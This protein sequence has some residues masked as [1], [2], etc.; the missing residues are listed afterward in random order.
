MVPSMA[1]PAT[2]ATP[3]SPI[4]VSHSAL[5]SKL[6]SRLV[7]ASGCIIY[8]YLS[9]WSYPAS[10]L[11][12]YL[13]EARPHRTADTAPGGRGIGPACNIARPRIIPEGGP[14]GLQGVIAR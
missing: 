11:S 14:P 6:Q 9:I 13:P 1:M 10:D 4:S 8:S 5:V 12:F 3:C 2:L 7:I